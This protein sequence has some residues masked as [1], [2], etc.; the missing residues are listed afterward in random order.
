MGQDTICWATVERWKRDLIAGDHREIDAAFVEDGVAPPRI[1]WAPRE[2][3]LPTPLMAVVLRHWQ[4]L[5]GADA[6]P[7]HGDID[8][9]DFVPALGYVN[10]LETVAGTADLRY[11]LFGSIAARIS[12]FDM[13]G[14]LQS[15]HPAS[16]YVAAFA[17][18]GS[19]ACIARREPLFT[20]RE[21]ARAE[22]TFRWPRLLL[23]LRGDCGRIVRLLTVTVPL[24]ANRNVIR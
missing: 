5:R 10:V 3:D 16:R 18:A 13:T 22:R 2:E 24:D 21:P 9:H 17:L 15:Q 11:R 23:P 14:R 1:R 8:P 6:A 12:G 7:H 20:E 19:N 4:R